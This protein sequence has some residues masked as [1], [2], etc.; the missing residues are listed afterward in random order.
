MRENNMVSV[1]VLAG[2]AGKRMNKPMPKQFL[3]LAGKPVIMHTLERLDRIDVINEIVVVC[4][5]DYKNFLT[6]CITSYMLKKKYILVDGGESRQDSVYRGLCATNNKVVIIHEA[7]R[8][9]VKEEEFMDIIENPNEAVIY[10]YSIPFTVSMRDGEYIGGLYERD[11]LVNIQLPQKFNRDVLMEAHKK[12]QI[13]GKIFTED[14]SM[15]YEY[16]DIKIK[17]ITGTPY[18]IK[19]TE[20]SDL[21]LGEQIYN[22]YI[23]GRD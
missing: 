13:E 21:I 2:G 6:N 20:P 14:S 1:V 11:K 18:N 4:H 22:E 5:Q 8:P 10:G 3:A 15:V 16:T 9:F 12:A 17:I 23:V 19:I 7:A